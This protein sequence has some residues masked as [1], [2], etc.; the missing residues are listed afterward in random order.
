MLTYIKEK[1]KENPELIKELLEYFGFAN[2][3]IRGKY[4][5]FGRDESSSKQGITLYLEENETL[6]VKDW[7]HNE[8]KDIFNYIISNKGFSFK[9]VLSKAKSILGIE[10]SYFCEYVEYKAFG[11][12]YSNIK[13]RK[14]VELKTY[15]ESVLKE[16]VSYG[17]RRFLKDNISLESQR[18]FDIGYSIKDQAIT[19]PIRNEF[20][21]LI[22]VKAR[23]NKEAE[24]NESK[25]YYLINCLMSQTLYGYSQN[26]QYL[27]SSD[28]IYVFESEKST[29]QCYTYGI[30]N[31]VSLG[32]GSISRKQVQMLIS[33]NPK[34]II[35]LHDVGFPLESVLRNIN[36]VKGYLKMS[37]IEL[38]YWD[39]FDK[40]YEDKISCTDKGKEF[41]DYIISSEIKMIGKEGKCC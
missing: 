2:I 3:R 29:M 20:G 34:K 1:L 35:F 37:Q 18:Y 23:I 25:Y 15:D 5:S 10:D 27:E 41:F 21:E 4:I 30:R 28:V 24:E 7:S 19:I 26:Y 40:N 16:Y 31:T 8:S 11:G 36:M 17:N 6:L 22:G 12:F 39:Y 38:G 32:S 33:L 9:D 14:S 13:R